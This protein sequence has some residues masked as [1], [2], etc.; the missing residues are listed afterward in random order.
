M[1]VKLSTG[2]RNNML[3]NKGFKESFQSGVI[4]IYSGAQPAT[5][6]SA[7][8]GTLLGIVTKDGAPFNFGD[9][10]NGLTFDD[11][12]NGI[13]SKSAD[14]W[15]FTGIATGTAGWF[16]LMGNAV[17]GLG[18]ST[19]LPRLDGSIGTSGADMNFT[20]IAIETGSVNMVN[21][22]QYEIEYQ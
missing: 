9:V 12:A 1:T 7:V 5:A 13:I 4:Y 10:T 15:K 8:T 17:D 16:R 11:P 22:F 20:S 3:N 19:T 21:I 6:D 18:A 14:Q 2:L